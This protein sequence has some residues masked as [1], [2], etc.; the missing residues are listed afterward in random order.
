MI[1]AEIIGKSIC[2]IWPLRKEAPRSSMPPYPVYC[3]EYSV[4][5]VDPVFLTDST[6]T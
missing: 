3:R 6:E 5:S 1:R 4:N 2:Y